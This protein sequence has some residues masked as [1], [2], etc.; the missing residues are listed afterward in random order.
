MARRRSPTIRFAHFLLKVRPAPLA[1][2]LKRFFRIKRE[3]ID[4]P[5]GKFWID[6]V[7]NLGIAIRQGSYEPGMRAVL[8][9]L[10]GPG[11]VF[12]DLGANEGYF[13]VLAARLTHPSG[14]VLAVEPQDRL[15]PIIEMNLHINQLNA[16]IMHAAVSDRQEVVTLHLSPN[17]NTGSSGLHRA[18]KYRLPTQSVTA[19]TL[20]TYL[21]KI[22]LQASIS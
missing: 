6:P 10:L 1:V 7:S 19:L 8:E 16:T 14:R 12:V 13:T 5:A 22:N 17:T 2:L 18:T 21:I 15:I 9:N 20:A 11:K 4:T 3:V